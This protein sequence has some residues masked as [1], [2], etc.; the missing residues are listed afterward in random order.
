MLKST[1]LWGGFYI[2][3]NIIM[4]I[5]K[6]FMKEAVNSPLL[7]SDLANME[8]YISESYHGRSLIE[9]L[10]NA[11]DAQATKF[12]IKKTSQNVYIIANNGRKFNNGDVLSICRSGAST[13]Q[14]K[15]NSIGF[16]GIGFK[17][18]VNYAQCVHL[19]SGEIELSFSKELTKELLGDNSNVPLI[20]IP[21][22][23]KDY[24]NYKSSIRDL[25][26]EGYNTVFIFEVNSDALSVE[27]DEFASTTMLFLQ[28]IKEISFSFDSK[29]V[30]FKINREKNKDMQLAVIN[31]QNQNSTWL[32]SSDNN[33]CSIAFQIND[34][35]KAVK[36]EKSDSVVHSFMPTK[37][38]TGMPIKFNGDF[39]TD[40][41]RTKIVIDD[42]T[43]A[44][45]KN[46][47]KILTEMIINIVSSENDENG[48]IGLLVGDIEKDALSAFRTER[49][50][51][52][53]INE[54]QDS[55]IN[56]FKIKLNASQYE[57]FYV[58]PAWLDFNDF[59]KICQENNILG[60]GDDIK[61]KIPNIVHFLKNVGFEE[62]SLEIAI[63]KS[64]DLDYSIE[65]RAKI[66]AE[67]VK[68]YRFG[69]NDNDK[70]LI[71]EA[72]LLEFETGCKSISAA[73]ESDKLLA[74]FYTMLLDLI[75][76]EKDLLWLLKK[77]NLYNDSTG[78]FSIN[79]KALMKNNDISTSQDSKIGSLTELFEGENIT[80]N[81]SFKEK[82]IFQKWRSVEENVAISFEN[83]RN[84]VKV[85]D[86]SK[87]NLG[88]DLE[89][90]WKDKI[91]YIEVKSVNNLGDSFSMTN[92]EYAT[93]T[94]YG[95]NYALVIAE[96]SDDTMKM[97]I[98]NNPISKLNLFKRVTRW[99][100]VCNEYRGSVFMKEEP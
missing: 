8:K 38:Y 19:I 49:I 62:L 12:L 56:N 5:Q 29:I 100:W 32:I 35:L 4:D 90:Q 45:T 47:V 55:F 88:Y 60:F 58:Q 98:I 13:K 85:T 72:N 70:N 24:N 91:N 69:F 81:I 93:A 25:I 77:F 14:R 40:P 37:D 28:N 26:E 16:R 95:D 67:I 83:M 39:S 57:K 7:L 61:R 51:D 66:F 50:S 17:S 84:V 6:S 73:N 27:M 71:L 23:F 59:V 3:D 11:D 52:I 80:H 86:V 10:Q 48:I 2:S 78:T 31:F 64:K 41:S 46:C 42:E 96:Q 21:H 1:D 82:H 74:A 54:L 87:S 43:L 65:S 18:I 9:L 53:I 99:E 44:A 89:V 76:D 33:R 22:A 92:N 94:E 30:N 34:N 20:R 97:C 36:M 63:S 15:G 68:K 79:D 75:D